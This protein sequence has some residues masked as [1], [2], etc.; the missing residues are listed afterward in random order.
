MKIP[1]EI[2]KIIENCTVVVKDYLEPW[3]SSDANVAKI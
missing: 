3:Q 1:P 2:I